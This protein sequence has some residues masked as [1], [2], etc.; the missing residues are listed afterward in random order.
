MFLNYDS[1][2]R[3]QKEK[4]NKFGYVYFFFYGEN[5]IG[6]IRRQLTRT[7]RKYLQHI[8]QGADISN[9]LRTLINW[10]TKDQKLNRKKRE[11]DINR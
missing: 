6:K 2:S 1:K 7:G 4:I 3:G 8:T 10:G 9:I 5:T 11:E